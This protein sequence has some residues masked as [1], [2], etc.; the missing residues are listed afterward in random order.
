MRRAMTAFVLFVATALIALPA[1]AAE[2]GFYLGLSAGQA[3]L[4]TQS[5]D[6][7][8]EGDY[9]LDGNDFGYKAFVGYRFLTFLAVEGS[10]VDF[11]GM[12]DELASV[13]ASYEVGV[14]GVDL[15][16]VGMI[17]L[18]IADIFFKAG[19]LDW[20]SDLEARVGDV[21]SAF[22]S[23]GTDP[24]YGVGAQ[25]RIKHFAIRAEVEY[26]DVEATEDLYM[27]S[28]GASYTF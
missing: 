22:S 8:F 13:D 9:E 21:H 24:A 17:P 25:F 16:A 19:M 20:D 4:T 23:D 3:D 5:F 18:G 1:T 14:K 12:E 10:Y 6:E 7:D 27:Y 15:F 11:G 2:N 28:I 26:F